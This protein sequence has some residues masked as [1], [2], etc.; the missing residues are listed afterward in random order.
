M[1]VRWES[2]SGAERTVQRAMKAAVIAIVVAVVGTLLSAYLTDWFNIGEDQPDPP[3][4]V[5]VPRVVAL[6]PYDYRIGRVPY[7][8]I[9]VENAG[10]T[11]A[12]NCILRWTPG[13]TVRVGS[14][15]IPTVAQT[16]RFGLQPGETLRFELKSAQ[17][18][19]AGGPVESRAW[20]ACD[21]ANSEPMVVE[22][23]VH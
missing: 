9:E 14:R 7:A 5:A 21:N 19:S 11:T 17:A 6:D 18:F 3:D 22:Q 23:F 8:N 13:I 20:I 16:R 1:R 15:D 12:E 4:Q 2:D 10:T